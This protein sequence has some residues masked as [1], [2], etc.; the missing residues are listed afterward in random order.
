M[1]LPIHIAAGGLALVLGAVALLV[2]KGG[3]TH[4]R[5]GLL[6]VYAMVVMATTAA[7][8]GNVVGGLMTLYFVGTALTT[9]RPASPW[10]RRI[11]AA[12]LTL[13]VGR[14]FRQRGGGGAVSPGP[15]REG[16]DRGGADGLLFGRVFF[17]GGGARG[18]RD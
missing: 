10:T 18:R 13:A 11:N 14:F 17:V 12:A 5:S 7:I 9:V 8:L 4:R 16:G 3:P 1:L 15:F 2:K 6:F